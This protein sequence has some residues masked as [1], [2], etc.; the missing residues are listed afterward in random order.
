MDQNQNLKAD[1]WKAI[2]CGF[3]LLINLLNGTAVEKHIF[4]D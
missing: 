3:G 2:D 1:I 4:L